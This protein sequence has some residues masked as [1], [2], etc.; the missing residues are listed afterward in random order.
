MAGTGVARP[1]A[2]ASGS[3][4]RQPGMIARA[5][6]RDVDGQPRWRSGLE[7]RPVGATS[8]GG[9][10][11]RPGLDGWVGGIRTVGPSGSE[12]SSTS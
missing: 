8:G 1:R 12:T 5:G 9:L 2:P 10:E 11:R 3:L 7:H 6:Q 4:E